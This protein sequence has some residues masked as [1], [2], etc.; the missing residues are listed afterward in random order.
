[1]SAESDTQIFTLSHVQPVLEAVVRRWNEVQP[2][3]RRALFEDFA[4]SIHPTRQRH[5]TKFLTVR[6]H[7]RTETTAH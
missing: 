6:W 5:G 3:E 2:R 7:N 1:M 4:H